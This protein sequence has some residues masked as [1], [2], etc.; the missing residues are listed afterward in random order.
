MKPIYYFTF[1]GLLLTLISSCLGTECRDCEAFNYDAAAF[2]PD[3]RQESFTMVDTAGA[4]ITFEFVNA[5]ATPE[6]EVCSSEVDS[7]NE[8]SCVTASTLSYRVA[9]LGFDMLLVFEEEEQF[10]AGSITQVVMSYELKSFETTQFLRTAAIIVEPEI[11]F[12]ADNVESVDS[13]TL[14]DVTWTDV[15]EVIRPVEAYEQVGDLIPESAHFTSLY[16][17]E[18]VG[19][20]GLVNA[21]GGVLVREM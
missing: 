21:S 17:K 3:F 11:V 1:A 13:V 4:D 6:Q 20:V 8:I 10:T 12:A 7:P 9:D 2:N 5:L 16:F 14:N 15:I 19:L 18:S